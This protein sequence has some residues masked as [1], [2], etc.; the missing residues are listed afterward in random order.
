[1]VIIGGTGV[2]KIDS[3]NLFISL[4]STFIWN[5]ESDIESKLYKMTALQ[6]YPTFHWFSNFT[7]LLFFFD[8]HLEAG[9]IT[10]FLLASLGQIEHLAHQT[11][12]QFR[13]SEEPHCCPLLLLS[14]TSKISL[15]TDLMFAE[16]HYFL[17]RYKKNNSYSC[18]GVLTK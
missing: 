16:C 14:S 10:S 6:I 9:R 2:C 3:V 18:F 17:K 12:I 15:N 1:M 11:P 7:S 5:G 13:F 4:E 8:V